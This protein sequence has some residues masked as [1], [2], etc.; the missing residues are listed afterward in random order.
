MLCSNIVCMYGG[1]REIH[2]IIEWSNI[3]ERCLRSSRLKTQ[4]FFFFFFFYITN[5]ILKKMNIWIRNIVR[6]LHSV[7]LCSWVLLTQSNNSF[8]SS[9]YVLQDWKPDVFR[10]FRTLEFPGSFQFFRTSK[11]FW[12]L[13]FLVFQSRKLPDHNRVKSKIQSNLHTYLNSKL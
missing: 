3:W 5:D 9:F 4:W 7:L 6:H 8:S 10:N 1:L 13:E 12:I 2:D 11:K